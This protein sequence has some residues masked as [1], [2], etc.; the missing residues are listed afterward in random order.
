MLVGKEARH[1][2][3]PELIEPKGVWHPLWGLAEALLSVHDGTLGAD[4]R[5]HAFIAACDLEDLGVDQVRALLQGRALA[6]GQPLCGVVPTSIW[7]R[8]RAIAQASG[9]V[10]TLLGELPELDVGAIRN[11]NHAPTPG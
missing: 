11:L 3:W 6:R 8:A 5:T 4:M 10:R 2:G 9:P 7:R 1:L